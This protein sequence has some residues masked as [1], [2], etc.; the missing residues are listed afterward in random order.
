MV[1]FSQTQYSGLK[2]PANIYK[3]LKSFIGCHI[4]EVSADN[5]SPHEYQKIMR[6]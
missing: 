5:S 2:F 4:Y 3:D 1:I 6:K